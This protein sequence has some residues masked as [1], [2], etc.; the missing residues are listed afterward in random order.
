MNVTE[1]LNCNDNEFLG[2]KR[3][4]YGFVQITREF[5][6]RLIEVLKVVGFIES[7]SGLC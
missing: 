4:I 2:L 5:Y 6:K 7:K 3:I 1:G